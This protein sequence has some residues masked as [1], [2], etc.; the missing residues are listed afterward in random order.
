MKLSYYTGQMRTEVSVQICN[1]VGV[2]S[3]SFHF[4]IFIYE[5]PMKQAA[6]PNSCIMKLQSA[7][8]GIVHESTERNRSGGSDFLMLY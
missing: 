4:F 6:K 7:E 1:F 3:V 2:A 5:H 8:T